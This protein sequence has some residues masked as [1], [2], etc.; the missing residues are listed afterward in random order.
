MRASES[1]GNR[2]RF[3]WRQRQM[4][5][6]LQSYNI[7]SV[8]SDSLIIVLGTAEN[9]RGTVNVIRIEF[10]YSGRRVGHGSHQLRSGKT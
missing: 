5:L 1:S 3:S 8:I 2:L 10:I 4:C 7:G 6:S 9:G